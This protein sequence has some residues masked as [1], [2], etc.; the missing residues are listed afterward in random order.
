MR[1]IVKQNKKIDLKIAATSFFMLAP[2]CE[3]TYFES[4]QPTIHKLYTLLEIIVLAYVAF[5]LLRDRPISKPVVALFVFQ[6]YLLVVTALF[7]G[8]IASVFKAIL[9]AVGIFLV[10]ETFYEKNWGSFLVGGITLYFIIAL[11]SLVSVYLFPDGLYRASGGVYT[12][13]YLYGHKNG[14]LFNLFP[15]IVFASIYSIKERTRSSDFFATL[16]IVMVF[17]NVAVL[18]SATSSVACCA[19]F[20]IYLIARK[21]KLPRISGGLLISLVIFIFVFILAG[22]V[23]AFFSDF[24]NVVD[25]DL[26]FSSR[27]YIWERAINA[28]WESPVFGFGLENTAV[29]KIRFG[30]F[31]TPHNFALCELFY[32]GVVGLL[33]LTI[34]VWTCLSKV[35]RAPKVRELNFLMFALLI[36]FA[37]STME[38]M[39]IGLVKFSAVLALIWCTSGAASQE[40]C[41][42][43]S[44]A[45]SRHFGWWRCRANARRTYRD[46]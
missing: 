38:S 26:T 18:E 42:S 33:L 23:Q 35:K 31:S 13:Y 16:F 40:Y 29:S 43:V 37:M 30:G 6:T 12:A 28:I 15:G 14:I 45:R 19:L 39:G 5:K 34:A 24:F 8:L 25:R 17:I 7:G 1:A 21:G 11:A 36:L 44:I 27:T 2:F 10:I 46:F 9:D 4:Q 32:G 41:H 22:G 3:P 20:V